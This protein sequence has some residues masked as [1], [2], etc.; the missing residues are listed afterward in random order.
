MADAIEYQVLSDNVVIA[1]KPALPQAV[2]KYYD[3]LAARLIFL[4]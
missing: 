2:T 3:L 1:S 4:K